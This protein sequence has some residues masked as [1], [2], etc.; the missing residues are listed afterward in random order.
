MKYIILLITCLVFGYPD[1]VKSQSY[2]LEDILATPFVSNLIASVNDENILFTVSEKGVRNVY[3]ASAPSYKL[4]KLTAFDEDDGQE[5]TSLTISADGHWAVFVKGGDHGA[6]T[7]V[8]PV[9]PS[10]SLVIQKIV[11]YSISLITLNVIRIGEGDFPIIHPSSKQI[12][13]LNKGD[14]YTAFIDGSGSGKQLFEVAGTASKIQWSPDGKKLV[15]TSK[16][17]DHSFI[18]V[19]EQGIKNIQWIAPSFYRDDFPCWSPD[20]SQ[21]AFIRQLGLGGKADSI[22]VKKPIS[23]AVMVAKLA[24]DESKEI[25][26][27]QTTLK[28]SVPVWQGNFNLNWP[29]TNNIVFLSYQDGWP[30]LYTINPNGNNFT[31]LTKGSFSVDQISFSSDGKQIAFSA[32]NG[33]DTQDIDRKHIGVVT[34][35]GG[36]TNMISSGEGI[37]SAPSFINNN[38]EIVAISGSA[39]QPGMPVIYTLEGKKLDL[40]VDELTG[41]FN[42]NQ[43][44]VPKQV[45]FKSD[46]GL[47]LHGQLFKP[48]HFK[49]KLPALLYVHGGP[50]R[51]MYLGWHF[52]DYYFNDYAFTQYL[53]NQGFIVLS[54]NYRTGTGYGYDFQNP[55]KAG[56]F[57]ASEYLDILSSGKWL[58]AQKDVDSHRIGIYGGSY[59]GYLTAMAL[60]K[61]SDIFKAGV[62]IHGVHNRLRKTTI[63]DTPADFKESAELAWQSSPSRWVEGWK[64]PVLII[65]GDDDQN[66]SF[67]QSLDLVNRLRDKKVDV[68]YLVIPDDTHHWLLFSNLKKVKKATAD[69]LIKQFKK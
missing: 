22:L 28:G 64:S 29:L 20:G 40:P 38:K 56:N 54:I 62:D 33:S 4:E 21:I 30:H 14:I 36:K 49:G 12:T 68:E 34:I 27:S 44:V 19:Y 51:Q 8:R 24:L 69:F 60:G 47:L 7:A 63:D 1:K 58:A 18:G 61:N 37:E 43:L 9:N 67:A 17:I 42:F 5:I 32:N 45:L 2:K 15:F 65:H 16:R 25:W 46:D 59:G 53:V 26:R 11:I 35:T 6:N 66:V 41:K 50:R 39:K 55:D 31:Q 57:G 23:W 10:S 3:R 13:Y 48:E 52:M